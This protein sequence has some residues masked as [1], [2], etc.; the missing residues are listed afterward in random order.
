M[1]QIRK[2]AKGFTLV[3]V[4]ASVVIISVILLGVAQL[5]NFTNKTAVSNNIKLVTT[6]LAKASIERI[7]IQ[8][9]AYFTEEQIAESAPITLNNCKGEN[10][11]TLYQ[12]IINDDVYHVTVYP[13]QDEKE[14]DLRLINVLVEVEHEKRGLKST[15]EGYVI[16]ET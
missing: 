14:S 6:H 16:N 8:P 1:R 9:E 11:E 13:S 2:H 12:L 3:E 7:K 4:L 15:V 5:F 10:C